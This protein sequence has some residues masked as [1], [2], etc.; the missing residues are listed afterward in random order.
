MKPCER[1]GVLFATSRPGRQDE[2][3][4]CSR[5]CAGAAAVGAFQDT[6]QVRA[7]IVAAADRLGPGALRREVAR[8]SGYHE[9]TVRR[10][11]RAIATESATTAGGA[12]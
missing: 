3:R 12:E 1:C 4:F 2:A 10:H 9:N 11:L 6:A 8:V 5:S 7:D